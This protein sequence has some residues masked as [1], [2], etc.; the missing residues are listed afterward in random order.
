[1]KT[2]K[3]QGIEAGINQI[4]V[5]WK[6]EFSQDTN[7]LKRFVNDLIGSC[8]SHYLTGVSQ[9]DIAESLMEAAIETALAIDDMSAAAKAL[10]TLHDHKNRAQT[11]ID[12]ISNNF[13]EAKSN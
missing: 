13:P 7:R 1:M 8:E 5:N 11:A 10:E 9:Q 12:F 4:K 2:N 3:F 6:G